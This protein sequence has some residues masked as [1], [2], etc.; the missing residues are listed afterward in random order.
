MRHRVGL[1]LGRLAGALAAAEHLPVVIEFNRDIRPIFADTCYACHGPDK[2]KR[3]QELPL[4]RE[5]SVYRIRK[6][7]RP[8]V[9]GDL[10][11]SELYARITSDDPDE[12]MPPAESQRKLSGRQ[13]A[14]IKKWIEQGAKWQG[15]WSFI[16]P[17]RPALPKVKK[18][19]WPRQHEMVNPIARPFHVF[20][21]R[22]CRP[23]RWDERPVPLPFR[24]LFNPHFNQRNLPRRKFALRFRWRHFFIGVIG[25]DTR[26]Q[27]TLHQVPATT[28]RTF[29]R[30]R[31]T[32]SSRSS[33]SSCLRL[34][35][36]GPWHA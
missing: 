30:L 27:F 12:K 23:L 18:K 5:E 6:D 34:F 17:K 8:V 36:S 2:N 9:A 29:L 28:G 19:D 10:V 20:H 14:L 15:H 24:A 13:I 16:P 22:K 31:N 32:L 33:R 26:K 25:S 21:L 4:D 3:K 1:I 35:L 7:V 11:E